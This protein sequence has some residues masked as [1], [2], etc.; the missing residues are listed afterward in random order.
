M[1]VRGGLVLSFYQIPGKIE[2]PP[3]VKFDQHNVGFSS[4]LVRS[5]IPFL[6][7]CG[8]HPDHDS[9]HCAAELLQPVLPSTF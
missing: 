4:Y 9:A 3:H 6:V 1:G 2:Q 5:L 8:A 7:E